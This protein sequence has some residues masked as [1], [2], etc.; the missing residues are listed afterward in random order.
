M[1]TEP[2]RPAPSRLTLPEVVELLVSHLECTEEHACDLVE[3]AIRSH[4]LR[5][6]VSFHPNGPELATDVTTWQAIE[7]ERGFV[8][9]EVSS[10]G[11]PPILVPILPLID[12]DEL[13]RTFQIDASNLAQ[14]T[15]DR[16]GRPTQRNWD[17]FWVEVFRRIYIHGLPDSQKKLVDE[18][19]DWFDDQRDLSIDEST[20]RKKISLLL[21]TLKSN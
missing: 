13:F 21:K 8:T 12:R 7:W 20:V 11:S 10:S 19:L 3:R 6:I 14:S 15:P 1:A 2:P 16:G 18:M 9:I 17:L 5:D 4:S